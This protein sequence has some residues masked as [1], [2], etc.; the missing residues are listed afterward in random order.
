VAQINAKSKQ[1]SKILATLLILICFGTAFLLSDTLMH[2][3]EQAC[4]SENC[5][6]C[7]SIAGAKTLLK[8]SSSTFLVFGC[9][10]ALIAIACLPAIAAKACTPVHLKTRLNN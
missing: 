7:A 2:D 3:H 1:A 10:L 5:A 8:Q 4:A 6:I 9:L